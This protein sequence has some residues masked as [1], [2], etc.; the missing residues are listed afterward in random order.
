MNSSTLTRRPEENNLTFTAGNVETEKRIDSA[1]YCCGNGMENRA[2]HLILLVCSDTIVNSFSTCGEP[3]LD[4][5]NSIGL[6]AVKLSIARSAI[7]IIGIHHNWLLSALKL[8]YHSGKWKIRG[9]GLRRRLAALFFPPL[10]YTLC[11]LSDF[12]WN[13]VQLGV[14]W[15]KAHVRTREQNRQVML[16]LLRSEPTPLS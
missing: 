9:F 14:L 15:H 3:W 6:G 1:V 2:L 11:L 7:V 16:I 4:P 8:A 5:C 12:E 13:Q 10:I